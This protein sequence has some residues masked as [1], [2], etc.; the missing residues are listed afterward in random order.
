MVLKMHL[1]SIK[2]E[3]VERKKFEKKKPTRIRF[4]TI[5]HFSL[6]LKLIEFKHTATILI[7]NIWKA[8]NVA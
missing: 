5:F 3:K 8:P 2:T 1:Q 6:I 7:A 4:S